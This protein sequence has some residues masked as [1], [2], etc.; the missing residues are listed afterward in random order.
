MVPPMSRT[1]ITFAFHPQEEVP[2][3]YNLTCDVKRKPNKLSINIKGEGYAVHPYIQLEQPE[4]SV[5]VGTI[6]N[7]FFT[8]RPAPFV[9]YA[10]FGVVQVLDTVS[11]VLTV[12]N[13]GKYN[14]DY[15]WEKDN[16]DS[17][18]TLALQQGAKY[19][20]TLAKGEEISYKLTFSPQ[21]EAMLT[22]SMLTFTVGG[23]YN[24]NIV[25][26]GNAVSPALRFSFTRED[27]GP[28]FITSPGGSTVIEEKILR[29]VNHDPVNNI[30]VECDFQKTR[31]FW[32]ECPPTVLEPG[33]IMDVPIKFAPR[34]V[35]DYEFIVPFV[36]NGTSKVPINISGRGI[37]PRLEL[38]N[39]SQ[40]RVNYGIVNV[41]GEYR[42]SIALVNR[43]KKALPIKLIEE[44]GRLEDN[45]IQFSPHSEFVIQP[46]ETFT[47][48]VAFAPGRRVG[49][50]N[51]DLLVHY[52]GITRKLL[53]ISGKA[54]GMEVNLDTDSLPFG[55]VV[56][57]SQ[58]I[59]KLSLENTGD[60]PL[61]FQWMEGTFGKHFSIS[62]LTGKLTPGSEISFDVIFKPQFVDEDIRQEKIMLMIPGLS[63]L[64]VTCTGSCVPQGNDSITTLEFSSL[65]RKAE[66]KAVKINNP[67]DKDWYLS[68]SL[69]GIHWEVPHEFKVPAKG[70]ADMQV[71]YFPLSM[72]S[73]PQAGEEDKGHVGKVFVALPDGSAMLYQLK[74]YAGPP[75]CSGV[76]NIDT[77]AKKPSTVTLKVQ[78]WLGETQKLSVSVQLTEMPSPATNTIQDLSAGSIQP[79]Q[80]FR[81]SGSL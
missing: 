7:R 30:S 50:F 60:L 72:C 78:N 66:T 45:C 58:K 69:Q 4:D 19:G 22:G 36:I 54:Q 41:G 61:G 40:H 38:A 76:V 81:S 53:S 28:C 62:P 44:S 13:N 14:F 12:T 25:A 18:L 3:N 71:K 39:Q 42:K 5:A 49:L 35:K 31:A 2:Y 32:V 73:K 75:E 43:S 27:F 9:N 37:I 70:S 46:R 63:P 68:P 56:K 26:R 34:E 6:T 59:K 11:R 77:A 20:G 51:E 80:S 48:Q 23:K 52:A 21:K 24:Y 64:S 57:D 29:M 17:S 47:I 8:L 1:A 16:M 55:V 67:S 79:C 10:D 65:A 15:L 74:G 33:G